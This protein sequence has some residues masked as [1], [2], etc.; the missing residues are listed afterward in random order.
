MDVDAKDA[1]D[2]PLARNNVD[3]LNYKKHGRRVLGMRYVRRQDLMCRQGRGRSLS[4]AGQT[5]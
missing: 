5:R 4:D 3:A 2:L 1:H